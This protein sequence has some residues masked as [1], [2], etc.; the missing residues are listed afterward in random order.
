M[1]IE[2]IKNCKKENI[3]VKLQELAY[4]LVNTSDVACFHKTT[5]DQDDQS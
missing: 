1:E 2:N 4:K 5:T 3:K